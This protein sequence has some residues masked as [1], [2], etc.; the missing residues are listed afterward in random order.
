MSTGYYQD[1]L[2]FDDFDFENDFFSEENDLNA[3]CYLS[4]TE[5]NQ[6]LAPSSEKW[7]DFLPNENEAVVTM[8]SAREIQW[9]QAKEKIE[10]VKK[11][12]KVLL[13]FTTLISQ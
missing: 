6:F 3:D 10:H 1:H 2:L 8:D 11:T 13:Y 12:L 5:L 9:K 7:K 4:E